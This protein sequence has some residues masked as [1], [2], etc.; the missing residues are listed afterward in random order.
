LTLVATILGPGSA[1]GQSSSFRSPAGVKGYYLP[2]ANFI[3]PFEIFGIRQRV[4]V[5]NPTG[6]Y[7]LL[8]WN[9]ASAESDTMAWSGYRVRRTI[10]GIDAVPMVSGA[11]NGDLIGQFKA[12]DKLTKIC[13]S[14]RSFCDT[15]YNLLGIGGGFMFRGFRGNMRSD[16]SYVI[17]Y[18]ALWRTVPV[19]IADDLR[20]IW[21]SSSSQAF[22]VGAA[23]RILGYDGT[24]WSPLTS[25]VRANLNGISGSSGTSAFA[26]GDSCRLLRFNGSVWDTMP[27]P[28]GWARQITGTGPD[29]NYVPQA[30][31][32]HLRAVWATSP[33]DAF[34]AGDS[35]RLLHFNGS[36]WDT[37]PRP[38]VLVAPGVSQA[39][40][41]PL[42]GVWA[43]SATDAFAVGDSSLVLHY[44]GST[45][46]TMA[47]G[48]TTNLYA[49]WGAAA[50]D[51]F[52]VGDR[53]K[54]I[55]YNG[56]IWTP[57]ESGTYRRLRAVW[58][59]SSSDVFAAGGGGEV[60]HYDGN[61][62]G[63]WTSMSSVSPTPLKGVWG[64]SST[65]VFAAG[66]GA[67]MVRYDGANEIV[68]ECLRCRVFLDTGNLSGFHSRYAVTAIDTTA[69]EYREFDESDIDEIVEITAATPPPENLE[70][71]AVVP[72]PYKRSAEWDEPGRRKIHFIHLPDG[73]KVRI[74]TSSLE[75]V[76][77]LRLD[78]R[79]NPGGLTGELEWDMRNADGREVKTGIYLYQVE[80]TQGRSRVGHFVIIK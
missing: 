79:S 35:C 61:V 44:D 46:S 74:F 52:A 77:Q 64:A 67:A 25:P 8:V 4:T 65:N 51:L 26:A 75:L 27:R 70:H 31:L 32:T 29:T 57:M 80:T 78:A 53:G 24:Q 76:R 72:N 21:G 13:L 28:L 39:R 11:P 59:A 66:D 20:A 60:L 43:S 45:W 22:A 16:G 69:G 33:T 30:L 3:V 38:T 23:G 37:L 14:D 56:S 73:A 17:D 42:R 12:R 50:N 9:D 6:A 7:V 19:P 34:A 10:P 48:D 5:T 54:I 62:N 40:T 41:T 36:A 55:R 71:V 47:L 63:T 2:Y 49:L 15:D 68:D 18:R 1:A 58:G